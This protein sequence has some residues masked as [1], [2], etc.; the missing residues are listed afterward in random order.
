MAKTTVE[1]IYHDDTDTVPILQK[2]R[3]AHAEFFAADRLLYAP[4]KTEWI[5]FHNAWKV[6]WTAA[7][8]NTIRDT[9]YICR[10]VSL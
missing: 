1:E 8:V 4:W 5:E 3:S 9:V 2:A 6:N 10:P 7:V